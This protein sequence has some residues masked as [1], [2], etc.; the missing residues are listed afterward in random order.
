MDRIILPPPPS[1]VA[2]E[3][4]TLLIPCVGSTNPVFPGSEGTS[5]LFG[6]TIMAQRQDNGF[7]SCEVGM[8]TEDVEISVLGECFLFVDGDVVLWFSIV[9]ML[10]TTVHTCMYMYI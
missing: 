6:L 8:A 2:Y 4:D 9:Q 1:L 7:V 3:G 5:S 10:Q